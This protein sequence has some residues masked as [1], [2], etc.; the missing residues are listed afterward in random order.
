MPEQVE[1]LLN[2][3]ELDSFL[4]DERD[5]KAALVYARPFAKDEP[6]RSRGEAGQVSDA[7]KG[8]KDSL[9]QADKHKLEATEP[10]RA[11]TKSINDEYGE[12]KSTTSAAIEALERRALGFK[13]AEEK[14]LEAEQKAEQDRIDK[15]AQAKA[16]DAQAAAE[17]AEAE[18]ENPEAQKLAGEM[19]RDAAAAAVATPP[20]PL[21]PP[22]QLRG[23]FSSLGSLVTYQ[24]E[25]VDFSQLP[26]EHKAPND[27]TLKAAIKGEKAMAKA[28]RRE[29]N[30]QLIPGVRIWTKESGVSR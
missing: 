27:K 21:D 24:H 29:F 5:V 17:L 23:D 2:P 7:I 6:I 28:Q 16:A 26:E 11:T 19:H 8:L 30:L 14:R 10:Y 3:R 22:K 20:A 13:R 12:L 15:E 18:P 9:K 1:P 25:V 4:R